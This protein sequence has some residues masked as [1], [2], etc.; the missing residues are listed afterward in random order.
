MATNVIITFNTKPEK[1]SDFLAILENVKSE[2]PLVDGCNGV[3]IYSDNQNENV[4]TLVESWDSEE[5][6]KKHI[7]GIVESGGWEAIASHLSEEPKSSY[8][9]KL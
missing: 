8:F 7:S 4:F 5:L 6:H 1:N 2:L 9:S 3:E